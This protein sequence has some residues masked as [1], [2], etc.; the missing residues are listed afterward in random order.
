MQ[1][2]LNIDLPQLS[3]PIGYSDKILLVGS[4][5]TENMSD[6]LVQHRFN[7]LANPH[8]ILFNPFSVADSLDRYIEGRQYTGADLFHLNE[9]WNSWDHHTRFSHINKEEALK[10]INQSQ[11][12]AA[13]FIKEARWVIITLGSAFQYYLAE[14]GKPVANNHRAPGQW[15]DK[16]LLTIDVI[17]ERLSDTIVKL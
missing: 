3:P 15:F 13:M 17:K 1:L 9:L 2:S 8:G 5:F 12:D 10:G 16:R 14:T 11:A 7:V 4:C 6:R